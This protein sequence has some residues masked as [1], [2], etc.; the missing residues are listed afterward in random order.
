MK[1]TFPDNIFL[2]PEISFQVRIIHTIFQ[3]YN[4]E[5]KLNFNEMIMMSA[6]Y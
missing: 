3:L 6:L 4:D 5:I 1:S 2:L